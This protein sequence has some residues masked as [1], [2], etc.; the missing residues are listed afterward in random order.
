MI[1]TNIILVNQR[2]L[3]TKVFIYEY[4]NTKQKVVEAKYRD[5]VKISM[6]Q[7]ASDNRA[8]LYS[9]ETTKTVHLIN[10]NVRA[11]NI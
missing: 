8:I 4:R 9:K 1:L 10:L 11:R 7:E 5:R 6:V 3:S 2:A